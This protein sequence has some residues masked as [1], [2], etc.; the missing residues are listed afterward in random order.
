MSR[1]EPA[2]LLDG[3][4]P[5]RASATQ[6]WEAPVKLAYIVVLTGLS[7]MAGAQT[8]TFSWSV[9]DTGNGDGLIEPGEHA[10]LLL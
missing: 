8:M 1:Q 5:A 4:F 2:A 6:E 9:S 3:V 7:G 10:L